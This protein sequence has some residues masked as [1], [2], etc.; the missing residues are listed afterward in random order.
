MSSPAIV[1]WPLGLLL[2]FGALN[3]FGGGYYGMAGAEGIP[4]AWLAGSPFHDYFI[5]W[6]SGLQPITAAVA[7]AVL[8]LALL[9]PGGRRAR[10]EPR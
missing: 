8:A 7:V 5:G 3:A 10:L 4:T 1:R 2:G 9:L 6:V